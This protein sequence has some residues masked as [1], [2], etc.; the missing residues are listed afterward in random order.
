MQ[1]LI[2]PALS[3]AICFSSMAFAESSVISRNGSR[4]SAQ[5]PA[6][7]FTGSVVVDPLYAPSGSTH[8]GGHVSFS[9]GA[10]SDWHTHPAG[11]VLIITDGTGWVQ[12]NGGE[13]REVRPGD[14]IWTPPGVKHWH[15]ATASNSMRHIAITNMRE[16]R[17]VDW[18]E[19]VSDEQYRK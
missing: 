6:Q 14:V 4:A 9:P 8:V 18:L 12:E 16:G 15:G 1:S 5:G 7:N 2:W 3:L 17:N 10:R 13:K 19:K 11:Q